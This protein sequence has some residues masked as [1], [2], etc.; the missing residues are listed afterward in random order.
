MVLGIPTVKRDHQSYLQVIHNF[1]ICPLWPFWPFWL[2][3][4]F[5]P[6]FAFWPLNVPKAV[7]K[8]LWYILGIPIVKRD[9]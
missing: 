9:Q 3:W 6:F 7:H 5:W 8:S 1:F 4:P 2:F